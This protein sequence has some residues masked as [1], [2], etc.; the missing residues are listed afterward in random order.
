MARA[1]AIQSRSAIGPVHRPKTAGAPLGSSGNVTRNSSH[2]GASD[3]P[4]RDTNS[5]PRAATMHVASDNID[6]G[7]SAIRTSPLPVDATVDCE[8]HAAA[9]VHT[10]MPASF[11]LD[12]TE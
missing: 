1:I 8:I 5:T 10:R 3:P 7:R 6:K 12:R 9:A 4:A 11:D 2:R